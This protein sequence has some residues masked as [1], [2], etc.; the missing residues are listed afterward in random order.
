MEDG[1]TFCTLNLP[2]EAQP[3]DERIMPQREIASRG[4]EPW[5]ISAGIEGRL[6]HRLCRF[7]ARR[8]QT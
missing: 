5:R 4:L 6:E 7:L 8:N 2:V 3:G 1:T